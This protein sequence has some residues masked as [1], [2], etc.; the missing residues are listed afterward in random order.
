MYPKSRYAAEGVCFECHVVAW[1]YVLHESVELS[2]GF[3]SWSRALAGADHGAHD[4]GD[5]C[6]IGVERM[7]CDRT[8]RCAVYGR[9]LHGARHQPCSLFAVSAILRPW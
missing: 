2:A 6:V 9:F 7:N 8:P 5:R 1:Q 3:D 4:G